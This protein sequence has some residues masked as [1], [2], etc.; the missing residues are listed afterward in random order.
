[1]S[2]SLIQP[3]TDDTIAQAAAYLQ[4]GE[5]IAFATETVY[6]LGGDALNP[7]AIEKIFQT[8]RRPAND[9]LI[10]HVADLAQVQPLVTR[11]PPLAIALSEQ[12]WPGPLT[13]VLPKSSRVPDSVTSGLPHVA[14]RLPAH[15]VAQ[16]LLTAARCR[17]AAPSANRFGGI[18]PTQAAHV[19]AELGGEPAL[20]MILD[21]GPCQHGVESTVVRLDADDD[22][23]I[24][25]LRLGGVTLETLQAMDD[26][27]VTRPSGTAQKDEDAQASPGL[28]SRHYAPATPLMLVDDWPAAQ[29]LA[30][31]SSQRLGLL[32]FQQPGDVSSFAAVRALSPTGDMNEAATHLYA[33][34]RELDAMQ[35]DALVAIRLPEVHH[36][37]AIN[38]RLTRA[39]R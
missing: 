10:I 8:K 38:D 6:G 37:R 9:P 2:A 33:M 35:L 19:A 11:M 23:C 5:L 16:R 20:K 13:L 34:L 27:Q 12:F 21:G 30:S 29:R 17:I 14:V 7:T 4:A 3:P 26:V 1:M 28:L 31:D 36:G 24:E 15:P 25:V 18:S 22:Q 32:C 39:S